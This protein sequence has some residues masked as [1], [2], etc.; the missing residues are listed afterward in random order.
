MDQCPVQGESQT[1]IY[2]GLPCNGLVSCPGGSHRLSSAGNYPVIGISILSRG[3]HRL[4][5]TGDY[6]VMD[7]CPCPGGVIDS[8]ALNTRKPGDKCRPYEPLGSG[9]D[10]A[11]LHFVHVR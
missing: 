6:P 9:K 7:Q 5:S 3:S 8:H 2:W 10:L 1:L 4:S 11:I